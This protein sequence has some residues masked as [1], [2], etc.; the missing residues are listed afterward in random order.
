[1]ADK[2]DDKVVG[3]HD[4]RIAQALLGALDLAKYEATEA[5]AKS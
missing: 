1:M 2:M 5:L 3:L 4:G